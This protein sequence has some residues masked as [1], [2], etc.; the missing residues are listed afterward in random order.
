M[1]MRLAIVLVA[2]VLVPAATARSP[3][4]PELT[5]VPGDQ[6]LEQLP[7]GTT[8]WGE[9][10][11]LLAVW[12]SDTEDGVVAAI[13]VADLQGL[14]D[15]ANS[16]RADAMFIARFRLDHADRSGAGGRNGEWTLRGDFQPGNS[17]Q[18]SYWAE[19]PCLDG[20]D[21][22]GCAG[23]DRDIIDSIPGSY[24]VA[25]S[26]V[27]LTLEWEHLDVVAAGDGLVDLT[28]STQYVYPD[29]PVYQV[30]WDTDERET[31]EYRYGQVMSN[32]SAT[33]TQ[34]SS[35]AVPGS[36]EPLS[37]ASSSSAADSTGPVRPAPALFPAV[38]LAILAL[39]AVYRKNRGQ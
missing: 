2:L 5:D 1:G 29:W 26:T 27:F 4:T 19:G 11:D 38:I 34:P 31:A 3:G 36:S 10:L 23:G 28:A 39:T 9:G 25:S 37:A 13:H 21:E 12:F 20:N 17:E 15:E 18:W 24:D 22:D 30:D 6:Q 7:A 14:M 8:F 33:S 16:P 32:R 35:E